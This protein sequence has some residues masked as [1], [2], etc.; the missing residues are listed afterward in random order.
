MISWKSTRN[1]TYQAKREMILSLFAPS[2]V[3]NTLI[4]VMDSTLGRN[5]LFICGIN[6]KLM[7]VYFLVPHVKLTKLQLVQKLTFTCWYI[8]KT[9]NLHV[10]FAKRSLSSYPNFEII[11]YLTWTRNPNSCLFG[12]RRRN[13]NCVESFSPTLSVWRNIFKQCIANW[14]RKWILNCSYRITFT[15]CSFL[16][17]KWICEEPYFLFSDKSFL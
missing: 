10:Q 4:L 8:Q 11:P 16:V 9:D 3:V 5:A 13:A 14:N 1:A 12:I 2:L 6:I 15:H 17:K 7:L